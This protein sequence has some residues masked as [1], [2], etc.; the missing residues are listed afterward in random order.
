MSKAPIM[1]FFTDA[2]LAD[3][4]HL[5]TEAHGAMLLILLHT[6]RQG[7]EALPDDDKKMMRIVKVKSLTKWRSLKDELLPCFDLS[8]GRWRQKRLEKTWADVTEKISQNR[9]NAQRGVASR[10]ARNPPE[11]LDVGSAD[12]LD[13][14]N[15]SM[16]HEPI[17]HKPTVKAQRK[18]NKIKEEEDMMNISSAPALALEGLADVLADNSYFLPRGARRVSTDVRTRTQAALV[19]IEARLRPVSQERLSQIVSRLMLHFCSGD[20]NHRV[21][22]DY[23]AMLAE[24]PEDLLC[25]AYQHVLKHHKYN[26]LPKIADLIAVI[27]PE[28]T[29]RRT[30]K[31]KLEWLMQQAEEN[32]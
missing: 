24:F 17:N 19:E 27:D 6:W 18:N 26:N 1:P 15:L 7:G 12:A 30:L 20:K 28:L 9:E 22:S 3:C 5:S 2:Y 23:C 14:L 4:H 8:D 29:H 32:A 10:K 16:N 13:S 25:A 11:S 31:R 21:F